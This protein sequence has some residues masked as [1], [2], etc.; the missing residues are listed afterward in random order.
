MHEIVAAKDRTALLREGIV[1]VDAELRE[2]RLLLEVTGAPDD[3]V[4]HVAG[5][6]FGPGTRVTVV[7][8]LP[9]RLYARPSVGHMER[10]KRRLQLRYVIWPDEHVGD[11]VVAEDEESVVVLGL[12]CVSAECQ[13]GEATEVP[14]HVYLDQPLG[15][16]IVIDG[17]SGEVVPYK[18]AWSVEEAASRPDEGG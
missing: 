2:G 13:E 16:R 6:R 14:T 10:E 9:R 3:R 15:D 17:C 4:R 7:D 8:E 12:I 5:E 11:V 18:N 1:V